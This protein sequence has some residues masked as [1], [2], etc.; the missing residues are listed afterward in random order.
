MKTDPYKR[1]IQSNPDSWFYSR[2]RGLDYEKEVAYKKI[3][4]LVNENIKLKNEL[5][6]QERK[7]N[8]LQKHNNKIVSIIAHDLRSPYNSVISVLDIIKM[9]TPDMDKKTM[10]SYLDIINQTTNNSL[11]LLDELLSWAVLN[12]NSGSFNPERINLF[13]LSM[14]VVEKLSPL[15]EL[16]EI[17]LL[18]NIPDNLNIIADTNMLEAIFRN[19]LS[20][21]IQYNVK[22]GTVTLSAASNNSATEIE[23]SDTGMGINKEYLKKLLTNNT[24]DETSETQSERWKGLGLLFCKEFVERHNGNLT[25]ESE[26]GK[27][28][29]VRFSLNSKSF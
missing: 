7:V 17:T 29:S 20:N 14:R 2:N 13:Q 25:I 5:K 28:T 11:E 24:S 4:D 15:A 8:E 9:G 27:G 21:S 18:N 26:E 6:N 19:I 16:K 1:Y 10:N 22:G 3:S 12:N 23:I